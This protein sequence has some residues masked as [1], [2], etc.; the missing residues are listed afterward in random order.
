M[1]DQEAIQETIQEQPRKRG[2][3]AGSKTAPL[4]VVEVIPA[5][6]TKCGSTR[7][8]VLSKR[9]RNIT[10]NAPNGQQ[11][12]HIVWRRCKCDACG[13]VRAEVSHEYRE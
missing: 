9:E 10:G 6:C 5:A 8:K 13:Q 12:T 4:V 3:P 11:R 1:S 2:R 7:R